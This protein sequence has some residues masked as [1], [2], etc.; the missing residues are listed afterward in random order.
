MHV[1]A[2]ERPGRWVIFTQADDGSLARLYSTNAR[3]KGM[4][5]IPWPASY[6]GNGSITDQIR[7]V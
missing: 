7:I 2:K 3:P 5:S 1:C 6:A 4:K